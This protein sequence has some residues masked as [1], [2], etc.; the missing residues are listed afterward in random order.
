MLMVHPLEVA[1][2]D[3]SRLVRAEQLLQSGWNHRGREA[4]SGR[5]DFYVTRSAAEHAVRCLQEHQSSH[6]EQPSFP[7][8]HSRRLIFR[9]MLYL[10][11]SRS[12]AIGMMRDGLKRKPRDLIACDKQSGQDRIGEHGKEVGH[13]ITFPRHWRSWEVMK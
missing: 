12:I 3:L 2:I 13:R 4:D 1:S 11:I 5:K 7:M 8:L 6:R 10:K 9:F